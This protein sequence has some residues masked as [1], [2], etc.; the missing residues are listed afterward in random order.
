[1]ALYEEPQF[2]TIPQM[3]LAQAQVEIAK[4]QREQTRLSR[5]PTLNVRGSLSQ[6]V[7][8]QN[9]NNNEDDGLYSSVMLEA[10]SNFYQGGAV[11]S[12]TRAAG[13]AE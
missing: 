9:P 7:N 5:Y 8:G 2:T 6:A 3:M 12:Q 11:T 1:S 4:S 13:Y 10:T